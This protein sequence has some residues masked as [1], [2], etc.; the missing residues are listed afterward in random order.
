MNGDGYITTNI[1]E[2]GT[3]DGTEIISDKSKESQFINLDIDMAKLK[4]KTD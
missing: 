2:T 3:V 1:A 4:E